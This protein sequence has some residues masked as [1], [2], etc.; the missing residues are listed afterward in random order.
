[1][2]SVIGLPVMDAVAL[3]ENMGLKVK[4]SKTGRVK[5]QSVSKGI[6]IK[7]NQIVELEVS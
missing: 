3:L 1:M 6:K 7:N 4:F 2:P 5:S